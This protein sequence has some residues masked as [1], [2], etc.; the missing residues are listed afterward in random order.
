MELENNIISLDKTLKMLGPLLTTSYLGCR[1]ILLVH[2]LPF[3]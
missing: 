3:I 1:T 2:I